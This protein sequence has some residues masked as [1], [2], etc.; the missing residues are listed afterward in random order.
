M[1]I[2]FIIVSLHKKYILPQAINQNTI[3]CLW[4][5]ESPEPQTS[6]IPRKLAAMYHEVEFTCY[7]GIYNIHFI[8][9]LPS[10][11]IHVSQ[12]PAV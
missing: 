3:V 11:H 8:L 2:A 7:Y 12:Y 9:V 5:R 1:N 6:R 4:T 10:P